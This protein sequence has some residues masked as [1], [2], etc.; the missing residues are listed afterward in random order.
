MSNN[1]KFGRGYDW[2]V[3]NTDFATLYPTQ[4]GFTYDEIRTLIS[5][6]PQYHGEEIGMLP[7]GDVLPRRVENMQRNNERDT[8][9]LTRRDL[10]RGRRELMRSLID[11]TDF[12]EQSI[13]RQEFQ[14]AS[15]VIFLD[16]DGTTKVIKNRYGRT[17]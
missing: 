16:D 1:F 5:V 12:E 3:I 17:N 2:I 8:I 6:P 7:S 15:I 13:S 10:S 11:Y 14:R 9:V 4:M